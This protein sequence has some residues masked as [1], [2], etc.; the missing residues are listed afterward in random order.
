MKESP[1]LLS[2]KISKYYKKNIWLKLEILNK[3]GSHKD[4]ESINLINEA[5][6]KR[7]N[8]IG[9]ASTG[10]LAI[11]LAFFSKIHGLKCFIWF[12]KKNLNK[13]KLKLIKKLGA[14]VYIKNTQSLKKLYDF[15][16]TFMK[17]KK[18]F[19]ANP[20]SSIKKITANTK[21]IKEIYKKTKKINTFITCV[22]NGTHILGI[23]KGLK[24]NDLLIGVITKSILAPSINTY[25]KYE[26]PSLKKNFNVKKNLI[27]ANS[28]NIKLGF[29]LLK[30][31]GINGSGASA[32]VVGSLSNKIFKCKKNICCIITGNPKINFTSLKKL[33]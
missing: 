3:T 7:Y 31:E 19:N 8:S 12:Q 13:D 20:N 5:K 16:N 6:S 25:T 4:R 11:S 1:L 15:S 26:F 27:R 21:I 9:C 10:N 33:F 29:S 24:K 32:A 28:S 14:Y 23:K 22:N 17:E 2:K 30:K 18:I